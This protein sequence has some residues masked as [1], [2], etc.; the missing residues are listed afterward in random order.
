MKKRIKDKFN[1]F[2]IIVS[3]NRE[4]V[5]ESNF[6]W[7]CFDFA[8]N[9]KFLHEKHKFICIHSMYRA[10]MWKAYICLMSSS[11]I[12]ILLGSKGDKPRLKSRFWTHLYYN[13]VPSLGP[14]KVED[15]TEPICWCCVDVDTHCTWQ[16]RLSCLVRRRQVTKKMRIR[17]KKGTVAFRNRF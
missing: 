11:Y 9:I 7:K 3:T 13:V 1:S 2:I 5:R 8:I 16:Q 6:S 14:G 10:F 15:E 4:S 17:K 12:D